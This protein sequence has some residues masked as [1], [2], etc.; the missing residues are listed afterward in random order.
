M[1]S[2][3]SGSR[4]LGG[5]DPSQQALIGVVQS[6]QSFDEN[7]YIECVLSAKRSLIVPPKKFPWDHKLSMPKIFHE[8]PKPSPTVFTID[9]E[10]H[11]RTKI[12]ADPDVLPQ[13]PLVKSHGKSKSRIA[14]V[15]WEQKLTAQRAA[16]I[17]KWRT[18]TAESLTS[19]Q[20]GLQLQLDNS[21]PGDVLDD[22][23]S[24]KAT[25]TLHARADTMID[26][27]HGARGRVTR[28]FLFRNLWYMLLCKMR[29]RGRLQLFQGAFAV[30]WLLLGMFWDVLQRSNV[31]LPGGSQ[32]MRR[33]VTRTRE[34]WFKS[35]HC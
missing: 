10:R 25:S 11:V 29:V 2:S 33:S 30:L 4:E 15:S 27:W 5:V 26:F 7:A 22:V 1:E 23:W 35:H 14:S 12:D 20:F 16:A 18:I 24:S 17:A 34:C 31:W 9:W 28:Q 32:D 19:F 3:S 6:D 8:L 21:D 13:N